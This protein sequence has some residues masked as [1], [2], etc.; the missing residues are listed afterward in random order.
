MDHELRMLSKRIDRLAR[1]SN[2]VASAII[3]PYCISNTV[4]GSVRGTVLAHMFACD[5]ILTRGIVRLGEKPEKPVIVNVSVMGD[6]SGE[7]REFA[8]SDRVLDEK[9][10]IPVMA[11]SCL[12]ISISSEVP[13]TSVWISILCIPSIPDTLIRRFLIDELDSNQKELLDEGI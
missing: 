6:D 5:G 3:S 12:H 9:L 8:I 13:L 2:K 4:I 7:G 1:R 10:N 11:K